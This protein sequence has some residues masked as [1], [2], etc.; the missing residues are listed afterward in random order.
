MTDDR[1]VRALEDVVAVEEMAPGMVQV[2]T[3]TGVH[4]V[5]AR[6]GGCDCEDKEYHNPPMCYHEYAAL[7]ATS[8][9][10]PSP[11]VDA[12]DAGTPTVMA[13]G[14]VSA[15]SWR[16]V[17]HDNNDN[18]KPADSK[19]D[20]ESKAKTAREFGSD[21]VSV[22]PPGEPLPGEDTE[23]QAVATE[24]TEA[25]VME[26]SE[27]SPEPATTTAEAAQHDLP[28]RSVS[29]DP[30]TW[31]PGEFVDEIDGTQ[32]I[33]RK[34]FEVLAHFYD[35]SVSADLEV[36]PEDTD[37]EYC[38]VKATAETPD[39]RTCEAYGSAHVDR[40]DDATLLLEMADTRAR[41]RALSIATGVGAV[42]V[43][44]LKS[45]AKQELEASD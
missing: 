24:P 38:R 22:V 7:I 29:D 41:K 42:A 16:V 11:Y 33:N 35:I 25:E 17:D 39:G 30:L 15:D 40:D 10:Y 36:P 37:H 1:A 14:G 6:D 5:D 31:V 19:A 3:W 43:S 26:V 45:E 27:P 2:T 28:E 9:R 13:D 8:D 18:V 12:T 23:T 34:G 21:N 32:A 4:T 20:A 44:E